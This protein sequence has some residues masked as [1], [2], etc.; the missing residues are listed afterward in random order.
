MIELLEY[1]FFQNAL[2]SAILVSVSC[3]IVGVLMMVNR[4]FSIA[5]GIT[6]GA[7]GG[8][9]LAFYFGLP[10]LLS[11][12]IFTLFLALLIAFLSKNF[13]HRSDSFIAVIWAFGMAFGVVLIDLSD[14]SGAD[15]MAYLFGS[16]L[17][18]DYAD[19][20]LMGALD[21]VAILLITCFYRQ[22]EALSFDAEFAK[23][24]GINTDFF[25]YLLIALMAFCIVICIRLVGLVLVLA[26]LSIPSFIAESWTRK[27]GS[28]MILA[29][30]LSAFFCISGLFLSAYFDLSSGAAIIAI[31][32]VGFVLNFGFKFL[33][34]A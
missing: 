26:L 5:G 6:H 9:G 20:W 11:A 8:I 15:L 7:F 18:V 23:T 21:L 32:C 25:H 31:A 33:K 3:A 1:N 28:M 24:K 4:L 16:I 27:L 30:I 19:L 10:V 14:R 29:G 2:I 17:A 12:S 34:Q 13:A 22:F